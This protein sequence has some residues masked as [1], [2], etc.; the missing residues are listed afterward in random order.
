MR[1]ENWVYAGL[2]GDW[3]ISRQRFFGVPV[4]AVALVK[5]GRYSLI[6]THPIT[7]SE[8]RLPIDLTDLRASWATPRISDVPG[9][10]YRR[11]G[12]HD[13]WATSSLTPADRTRWRSRE[14]N[15]ANF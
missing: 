4:L 12:H 10:L 8:D 13:T 1:Y 7:L 15:Q 11:A 6:T 9:G 14:E 2:N 3:L 5:E